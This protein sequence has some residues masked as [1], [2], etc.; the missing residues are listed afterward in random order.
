MPGC[1]ASFETRVSI[2]RFASLD[3]ANGRVGGE[4]ERPALAFAVAHDDLDVRQILALLSSGEHQLQ[5]RI[6]FHLGGRLA[7]VKSDAGAK[8]LDLAQTP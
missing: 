1:F 6:R 4:F 5:V 3:E 7:L 2:A 8:P